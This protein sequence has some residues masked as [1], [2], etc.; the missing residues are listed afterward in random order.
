M[1]IYGDSK[2]LF[3]IEYKKKVIGKFGVCL[4]KKYGLNIYIVNRLTLNN[5]EK[6]L[7][8]SKEEY[9]YQHIKHS[10]R[11]NL[12]LGIIIILPIENIITT[13]WTINLVKKILKIDTYK[14]GLL[15]LNKDKAVLEKE[16]KGRW[17]NALKKSMEQEIYI[18]IREDKKTLLNVANLY[19]KEKEEKNYSGINDELLAKWITSPENNQNK[20]FAVNAYFNNQRENESIGGALICKNDSTATYLLAFQ[21]PNKRVKFVS[22]RILWES[23]IY[24]KEIGCKYFDLGGIDENK[25]PGVALFKLGLRPKIHQ[26]GEA[27]ITWTK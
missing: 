6:D 12:N 9:I 5:L 25:T 16:M 26:D 15:D 27:I 3:E 10:L 18:E 2:Y 22:N 17:R 23:I 14:T 19:K 21:A 11:I 13:H 7:P 4:R 24:S 1:N 20:L 8:K